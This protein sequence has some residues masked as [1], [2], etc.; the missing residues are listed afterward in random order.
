MT[1]KAWQPESGGTLCL[2]GGTGFVGSRLAAHL[3]ARGWSLRL[4]TRDP[5]RV[6]HLKVLPNARLLRADVHDPATLG[7]LVAGCDAVINLV[8]IL[9]EAGYDGSGFRRAHT[10]LTEK[11]VAACQAAD[12]PKLVQISA[13][14][15][16]VKAPSHYLRSKGAA[17]AAIVEAT[18][19]R[20]TILQPSVI[21]GPGDSFLNRFA[22]LLGLLPLALPLARPGSRFAPVHIDDV[23]KAVDVCLHD[24]ATDARTFELCGGEIYSLRELVQLI[25]QATGRRRWIIGLP[26]WAARLQARVM[27]RLPGKLFTMDNYRSLG[28]P[29][30]CR[31]NG[32]EELGLTPRSLQ[33]NLRASLSL[34]Q[35]PAGSRQR[36]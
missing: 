11:V 15:A 17:E 30:V 25:A 26:D 21:F 9:N 1:A 29:S 35:E 20:W 13:L 10:E 16:D 3:A 36:A 8:G 6:R 28:L 33:L 24:G 31:S 22:D 23:V 27:E 7:Q 5:A 2:L 12:V 14:Q 18:D 32:L 19:L 4:P 34:P